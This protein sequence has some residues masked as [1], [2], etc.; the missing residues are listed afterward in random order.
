M[1]QAGYTS[2]ESVHEVMLNRPAESARIALDSRQ[3]TVI[4]DGYEAILAQGGAPQ[5]ERAAARIVAAKEALADGEEAVR[6][7]LNNAG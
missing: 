6:A 1:N 5:S 7:F 2:N 4:H 3:Q